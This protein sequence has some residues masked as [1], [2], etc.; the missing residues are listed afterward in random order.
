MANLPKQV[1]I[2]LKDLA[3][4]LSYYNVAVNSEEI[5]DLGITTY[6][7]MLSDVSKTSEC[8]V[9]PE[10]LESLVY[11]AKQVIFEKLRP[12]KVDLRKKSYFKMMEKL[13]NDIPQLFKTLSSGEIVFIDF[14]DRKSV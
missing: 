8:L 4:L 6:E 14:E 10:Q 1:R 11:H 13:S 2:E 5:G 9:T 7:E 3:N 12:V